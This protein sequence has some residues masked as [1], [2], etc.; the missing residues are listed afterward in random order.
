MEIFS[1]VLLSSPAATSL[2]YLWK[3]LAEL[4]RICKSPRDL[5]AGFLLMPLEVNFHQILEYQ[6]KKKIDLKG[7]KGESFKKLIGWESKTPSA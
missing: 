3:C 1:E 5:R 4:V 6:K 2:R 7:D